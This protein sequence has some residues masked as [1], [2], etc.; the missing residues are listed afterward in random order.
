MHAWWIVEKIVPRIFALNN[1]FICF[2]LKK[3]MQKKDLAMTNFLRESL[4]R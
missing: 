1:I 2:S 4:T 3:E